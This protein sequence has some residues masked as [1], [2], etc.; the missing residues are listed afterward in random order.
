MVTTLGSSTSTTTQEQQTENGTKLESPDEL[1]STTGLDLDQMLNNK[2]NSES[3][4]SYCF[5]SDQSIPLLGSNCSLGACRPQNNSS[6]SSTHNSSSRS[7]GSQCLYFHSQASCECVCN[8]PLGRLRNST[9]R[10]MRLGFCSQ[11][12]VWKALG[13]AASEELVSTPDTTRCAEIVRTIN[14]WDRL[15]QQLYDEFD[16]ILTRYD[17]N[18]GYS[19]RWNCSDCKEAYREWLCAMLVPFHVGSHKVRPCRSVCHQ[20][21]QQ[22]PY[23]LPDTKLQYAGEPTFACID[24]VMTEVPEMVPLLVIADPPNCYLPCHLEPSNLVSSST[25]WLHVWNSSQSENST[26]NTSETTLTTDNL[27]Y[28][29]PCHKLS[30]NNTLSNSAAA[31]SMSIADINESEA[32]SSQTNPSSPTSPSTS[33]AAS[34]Y[35]GLGRSYWVIVAIIQILVILMVETS[36]RG[37]TLRHCEPRNLRLT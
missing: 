11:Y 13:A 21:E 17:C 18:N 5:Y 22:C 31:P 25:T 36:L 2:Y 3:R 28:G 35:T 19:N 30:L 16:F 15:A 4:A 10:R 32:A 24:P 23:F 26:T 14:D 29:V 20:V 7:E 1:S 6:D 37:R 12:S 34:T 33:S 8:V 9:L 27:V